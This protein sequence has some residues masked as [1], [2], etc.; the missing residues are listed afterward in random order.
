MS[1]SLN[2]VMLI[3]NVGNDPEIRAT[4]SGARVAKLSLATNRSWSDRS[5]QQQEKTE[6][7]RLTVFG[8]LVDI[9][10]QWVHKGDRLYV[11]G[12]VEYSQTQDDQGGT[13]YWTDIVVNELL[14]LGSGGAGGGGYSGGGDY[15]SGGGFNRGGGG[16]EPSG[17]GSAD[18]DLPF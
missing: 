5:G 4:S 12:R 18:D 3:G 9:V 13:R 10:E 14:M 6:W 16:S 11:E 1:R 7:H 8:R 2:K 15:G 17:G